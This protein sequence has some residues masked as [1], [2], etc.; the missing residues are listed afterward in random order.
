MLR[1]HSESELYVY[2]DDRTI[3]G[4]PII[5]NLR[6]FQGA[7]WFGT[8][9]RMKAMNKWPM[10]PGRIHVYARSGHF[11]WAYSLGVILWPILL[12][13]CDISSAIGRWSLRTVHYQPRGMRCS[14]LHFDV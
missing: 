6:L 4:N 13:E 10:G 1:W 12:G 8:S 9:L 3:L 2:Y 5:V 7:R 11:A 14:V